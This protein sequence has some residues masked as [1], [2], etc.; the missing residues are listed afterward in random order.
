[1]NQYWTLIYS[2]DWASFKNIIKKLSSF[3]DTYLALSET[4][5]MNHTDIRLFEIV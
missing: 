2:E 5:F 4:W 1:M 3:S